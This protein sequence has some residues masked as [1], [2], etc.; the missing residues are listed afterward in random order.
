MH[1]ANGLSSQLFSL[2]L[3]RQQNAIVFAEKIEFVRRKS[4]LTSL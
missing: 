3:L 1:D 4:K 2:D